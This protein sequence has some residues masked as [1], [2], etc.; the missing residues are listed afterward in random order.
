MIGFVGDPPNDLWLGLYCD[1]DFAGDKK[2]RKSPSGVLLVLLSPRTFFPLTAVSKRQTAVS[3]SSTEAEVVGANEGVRAVGIPALDLWE[4]ILQRTPELRV[5]ED[6]QATLRILQTGKFP[7]LQHIGRTH[8]VS[9]SWLHDV[10]TKGHFKLQ[11]V[12]TKR[13][14]ADVFT[15]AFSVPEA[16]Q[17]AIRLIGVVKGSFISSSHSCAAAILRRASVSSAAFEEKDSKVIS[18][19]MSSGS[20]GSGEQPK[21]PVTPHP[22]SD[23]RQLGRGIA[24][25]K[26]NMPPRSVV[27]A[28]APAKGSGKGKGGKRG[29]GAAEYGWGGKSRGKGKGG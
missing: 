20:Q 15:K 19:A 3:H 24:K 22:A 1:S 21:A 12:H 28:A 6:N 27:A 7:K 29:E 25:P 2:D 11:D 9:V 8:G 23:G 14:C 13:Q 18:E 16:W 10:L 4:H 26:G 5:Y 17:L